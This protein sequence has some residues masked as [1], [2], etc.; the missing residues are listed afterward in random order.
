M[1]IDPNHP[2][3]LPRPDHPAAHSLSALAVIARGELRGD[4]LSVAGTTSSSAQVRAG[5]LFA[6][7]PGG[8]GHGAS[9]AG[10]AIAAGAVAVLTDPAGVALLPAAVPVIVVDDVRARLA[11]VAAEIYGHP[12]RQLPVV[13]ITGTSGKTTTSFLLRAALVAA[14]RRPGLIGTVATLIDDLPVDTGFTTPEAPELQALLASMVEHGC[15]SAVMEV[16]S[17]AL[18]LGRADAIEFAVGAFTNLSQDHLDFH[19]DMQHYFAAKARL[20]EEGRSRRSVIVVDDEWGDELATRIGPEA[21]TVSTTGSVATWRSADVR[22]HADGTTRFRAVG[23]GFDI[24]AGC[25]VPGGYNIANALLSLAIAHELGLDLDVAATAIAHAS[26]PGRMERIDAGQDFLTV[27]DYSHKP[28]AVGG[29]LRALRPLTRGRLI[30]VL[31]C[32]GDRDRGKRPMMGRVAALG[33]D[34]V[35]ITDD[36]PRSEDP[37]AI[38]AAMLEGALA[39]APDERGEVVEIGDRAAAIRF[40]IDAARPDDTV[41]V[42][43]KGHETG[44]EIDGRVL[45]FDDRVVV[46]G[47]IEAKS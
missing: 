10:A 27:V 44:Q 22:T 45:P 43:G 30:I 15:A 17:H 46:R 3:V 47:A 28:A 40:A 4:D 23:P 6:G 12:A 32:G 37:R 29:A 35:V 19:G 7:V 24:A 5:D 41:L 14:G 36:N 31:G 1:P 20:F 11:A 34:L 33:A 39:P 26:V 42:A 25:A 38:R 2:V 9:F 16:S 18:A 21:V 13:G 8:H